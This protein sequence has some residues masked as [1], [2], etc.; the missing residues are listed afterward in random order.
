[1]YVIPAVN[2][3]NSQFCYYCA[4]NDCANSIADVVT[5]AIVIGYGDAISI[6]QFV[7]QKLTIH[8]EKCVKHTYTHRMREARKS[9]CV[10]I[11]LKQMQKEISR[12]PLGTHSM[13]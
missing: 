6:D 10:V 4:V 9:M 8:R 5:A 12:H 7:R 1:M 2:H 11:Y 3:Q 13:K